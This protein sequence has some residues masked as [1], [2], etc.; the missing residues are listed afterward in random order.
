MHRDLRHATPASSCWTMSPCCSPQ[1]GSRGTRTHN[2]FTRT[3]FQDRALIRPDDFQHE[4]SDARPKSK[5]PTIAPLAICLPERPAGVEPAL[6][7]WQGSRLP[8]HH[9]R[10]VKRRIVKELEEHRVGLEPTSPRYEGGILPLND[11]CFLRG[12]EAGNRSRIRFLR[13]T[14]L[15][16]VSCPGRT[17]GARTQTRPVKSRGCCR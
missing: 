10:V 3:C 13:T 12:Q 5:P 16:P 7:P 17:A 2:G 1:G 9:G 6:P 15:S 8:L 14:V 11:Q 4:S